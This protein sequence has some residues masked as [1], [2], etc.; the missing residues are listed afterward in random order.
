MWGMIVIFTIE[1]FLQGLIESISKFKIGDVTTIGEFWIL[2]NRKLSFQRIE[3]ELSK[4]PEV[5]DWKPKTRIKS[6]IPLSEEGVEKECKSLKIPVS[7]SRENHCRCESV[8]EKLNENYTIPTF[9]KDK[10]RSSIK[11]LQGGG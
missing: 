5:Q 11:A 4:K 2:E 3:K 10:E 7:K 6:G 1:I 9:I 8:P